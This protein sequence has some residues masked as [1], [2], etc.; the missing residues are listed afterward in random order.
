MSGFNNQSIMPD[1]QVYIT[2]HTRAHTHHTTPHT[3]THTHMHDFAILDVFPPY[4][5][6]STESEMTLMSWARPIQHSEPVVLLKQPP[7]PL[8][9][10]L[11]LSDNI[12]I[13]CEF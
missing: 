13:G 12:F 2:P 3:H 11:V 6:L 9:Q 1:F 10:K 4:S 8:G 5:Q 7:D